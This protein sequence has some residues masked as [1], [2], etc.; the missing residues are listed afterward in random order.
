[1]LVLGARYLVNGAVS[2]AKAA[3][4]SEIVIGLTIVAAGTSLPEA[5]AS[6]T[7][8]LRGKREIAVGNVV[9][10]NIA[11]SYWCSGLPRW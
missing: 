10:S 9:G 8:T 2:A 5:A 1:M 3:G 11:T 4:L 6:I 7:A